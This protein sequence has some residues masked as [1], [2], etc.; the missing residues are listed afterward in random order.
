[1]QTGRLKRIAVDEAHCCSQCMS[2]WL[3]QPFVWHFIHCCDLVMVIAQGETTS[4]LVGAQ[5][6]HGPVICELHRWWEACM[7]G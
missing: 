3:P 2:Y 5:S 6:Q 4:G 7:T 1:M